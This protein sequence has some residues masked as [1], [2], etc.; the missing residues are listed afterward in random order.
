MSRT[1]LA[2]VS[3]FT[4]IIDALADQ[5]G[6][7]RAAVFGRIWRYC[8]MEDGVCKA[9]LDTLSKGLGVD[10]ATVMRHAAALVADGYLKDLT[11]EL[12]NR[13]HVYAD[14]GKASIRIGIGATVAQ[15]NVTVAEC[16]TTVA[17]RNATVAESQL[18]KDSK[19][20][21]KRDHQE[22]GAAQIL[23][24][25]DQYLHTR[26]NGTYAT[27]NP[28]TSVDEKPNRVTVRVAVAQPD[29]EQ[30]I[31]E[32]LSALTRKRFAVSIEQDAPPPSDPSDPI[33]ALH[34]FHDQLVGSP[35]F[36][37]SFDD[38]A[39]L[40]CAQHYTPDQYT[41]TYQRIKSDRFWKS[42]PVT[43]ETVAKHIADTGVSHALNSRSH[44]PIQYTPA[45]L[46]AAEAINAARRAQS[47]V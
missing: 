47:G 44:S 18:N 17:Q 39:L 32:V 21:S 38:K 33:P 7:I 20:P 14:T 11:P 31:R 1:V 2:D 43:P 27:V 34:Q 30:G 6:L 45:Q 40:F 19:R 24:A 10:R 42:K 4:P 5:H 46:A 35:C 8:Q 25:V 23:Q 36:Y 28:R 16:N 26:F 22:T 3:G 9:S 12:K 15:C 41:A 13:P 29:L 37:S